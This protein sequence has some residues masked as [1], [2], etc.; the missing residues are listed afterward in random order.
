MDLVENKLSMATGTVQVRGK[1]KNRQNALT[2]GNF[3]RVRLALDKARDKLLVPDRAV[4]L[5]QA[6]TFLLIVGSDNKVEKRKVKVGPLHP[7]DK[8]L[9]V[10]D[11]GLKPKEWVIIEGRQRVRPGMEVQ[12][13]N[14]APPEKP[15]TPP[16]QSPAKK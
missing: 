12:L 6:D 15:A 9:R 8:T 1:L 10:I 3:V 7:D 4:V 16:K 2:P 13:K 14:V 11:E 5:E